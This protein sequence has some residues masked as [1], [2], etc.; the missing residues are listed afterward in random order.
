MDELHAVQAWLLAASA[1]NLLVMAVL[2]TL[3]RSPPSRVLVVVLLSGVVLLTGG[4][5]WA[6]VQ[7]LPHR[8]A[9]P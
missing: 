1:I 5:G 6:I 7:A 2:L 9:R 4:A 3:L 8:E